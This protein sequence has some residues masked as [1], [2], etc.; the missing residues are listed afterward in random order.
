MK[1]FNLI[2]LI[3][4]SLFASNVNAQKT[5]FNKD[6]I[7]QP[8]FE[9][10]PELV[11]LYWK[12]WELAYNHIREQE[13]I[14]QSPYMDE[15][16]WDD[17]IWIW[18]TEFMVLF[19]KYAPELFPGIESLNNF[20]ESILNSK[21]SSLKIQHPDNP[22]FFAWVESDYYNF[23]NDKSHLITLIKENQFLQRHYDW[24]ESLKP[25]MKLHFNHA[26]I[27]LEKKEKGYKWGGI[28][29]GMDNTPRGRKKQHQ[30][31]WVDALA[32]QALSALYISRLAE[33]IKDKKTAL[34][35][36][37][38]YTKKRKLLNKYYWDKTDGFYYDILETDTSFVKVRTPASYWVMLAEVPDKAQAKK[39]LEYAN[40]PME[41]G[42]KYPWPTVSR[43][44][45]DFNDKYG[46]YW[47]GSIWVPTAY[48]ATKA[49]EKYGFYD[50]AD[51]NAY[52]LLLLMSETYQ[53]YQPAT[54]WECYNPSK[55]EPSQRVYGSNLEVVRPDFCG[56][57]ALAPI[58]MFI[59][60]VLGF[61]YVNAQ[62]KTVE[63]RKY[64]KGT[65]GIKNLR[66]GDVRT[67]IM[68]Y[69]THIEVVSNAE[70][71]LKINNVKHKIKEGIQH[72]K[73]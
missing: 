60:N 17:T 32:Q 6:L 37:K 19:C 64:R 43:R 39:L 8:V 11:D 36:K 14:F 63:W 59:E 26:G 61:H 48:M 35:F 29:S 44:D 73:L 27:L 72:I 42:G 22:P 5:P 23:T 53:T 13:G 4:L 45:K 38:E 21:S 25:G 10:K 55:P 18:D 67:D 12:A 33:L 57:S 9:E 34:L 1:I 49:L 2:I 68:A 69:N 30:I 52:N 31:L 65:Y 3:L 7:P 40:D 70:Y 50:V 54:I 16:L 47:K 41:F 66:F 46:D 62:T 58:S 20:Y 51:K 56:W 24:F 15:A 28:Q 71:I